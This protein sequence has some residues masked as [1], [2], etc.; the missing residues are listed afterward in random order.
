VLL[1]KC[2]FMSNSSL[3]WLVA[4]KIKRSSILRFDK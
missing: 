2:N 1:L 4:D 3:G